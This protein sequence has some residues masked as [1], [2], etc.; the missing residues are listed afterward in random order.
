MKTIIIITVFF[1][2]FSPSV[3]ANQFLN[4]ITKS[5][6][7]SIQLVGFGNITPNANQQKY[8]SKYKIGKDYEGGVFNLSQHRDLDSNY[9]TIWFYSTIKKDQLIHGSG[10]FWHLIITPSE[11]QRRHSVRGYMKDVYMQMSLDNKIITRKDFN[12]LIDRKT[13]HQGFFLNNPNTDTFIQSEINKV[14][15]KL[16]QNRNMKAVY[17]EIN[18]ND[19]PYMDFS[20]VLHHVVI[21]PQLI[22]IER[23]GY[24]L[25]TSKKLI[26]RGLAHGLVLDSEGNCLAHKTIK[27]E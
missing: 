7:D 5:C 17:E 24:L 3:Y 22:N 27:I 13:K 26:K 16:I 20:L 15:E 19:P 12:Y 23:G 8:Q 25:P 10:L 21:D 4:N 2:V 11:I 14:W 6:D 18:S 1:S 9:S